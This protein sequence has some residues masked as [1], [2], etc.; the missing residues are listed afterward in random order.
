MT[1]NFCAIGYPARSVDASNYALAQSLSSV[2]A[3]LAL[4]VMLRWLE[5]PMWPRPR[6]IFGALAASLAMLG[7]DLPLRSASPGVV[8][9]AAQII[10]GGFRLSRRGDGSG[11]RRR[12]K[13]VKAPDCRPVD[14]V[15][16][17]FPISATGK[18]RRKT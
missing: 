14:W 13:P 12:A 8:T 2:A 6:D 3:M 4:A 11:C 15:M 9:M 7:A 16:P 17:R 18:F 10:L 1:A 5:E